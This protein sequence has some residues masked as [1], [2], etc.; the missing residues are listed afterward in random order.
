MQ[1]TELQSDC[2]VTIMQFTVAYKLIC[3]LNGRQY[4]LYTA[5]YAVSRRVLYEEYSHSL[6]GRRCRR[7]LLN[8]LRWHTSSPGKM[9]RLFLIY[10]WWFVINL[11]GWVWRRMNK[12]LIYKESFFW[13]NALIHRVFVNHLTVV[14]KL[15]WKLHWNN[16]SFIPNNLFTKHKFT[17]I[18]QTSQREHKQVCTVYTVNKYISKH[19]HFTGAF[20]TQ[21]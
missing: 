13:T 20:A 2:H 9:H 21:T 1:F 5:L 16:E 8:Y 19:M 18:N 4:A 10:W 14:W 15:W 11:A 7:S 12:L 17:E 3:F 6:E